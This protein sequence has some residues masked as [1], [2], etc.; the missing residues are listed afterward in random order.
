M[1]E[2][3]PTVARAERKTVSEA[4]E[5]YLEHLT[6]L[7]QRKPTTLQD[8]RDYDG[9]RLLSDVNASSDADRTRTGVSCASPWV[10][11]GIRLGS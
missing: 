10:R 6:R 5:R 11:G 1:Q 9:K 7:R 2:G 4:G 8:Y 3:H